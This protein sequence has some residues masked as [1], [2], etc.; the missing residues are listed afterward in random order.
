[1]KLFTFL[2]LLFFS[3][4]M[5]FSIDINTKNIRIIRDKYGVPHI[6]GKTDEEVAYGLGWA[7]AED[8]FKSM[9]ENFLTSRG[10]LAE[11]KGKDG[12]IMDFLCTVLGAKQTVDKLYD[13][14]FSPKFKDMLSAYV[15][16]VNKFADKHP[17]QV[18]LKDAFPVTEKDIIIGYTMGLA[19]M[20][21]V[22]FDI[23]KITNGT[24][25]HYEP[26]TMPKGSNGF[27]VNSHKTKDG[28][29]YLGINSHQPL[30]GPYSWYEAHLHSDEGWNMLGGTFPG[31]LTIFHGTNENLGW[32]H[33]VSFADYSDVYKLRMHPTEKLTYYYNG[34]WLRLIEKEC[35]MKVK[36]FWFIK[37]PVT[38]KY[39][40]SVYGPTLEHDGSFYSLRFP[41]AFDIRGAEQWYHMNKAK[42]L[43]EFK[44]CLKMQ[45][46]PGLNIV[47][48]DNK[49]NI[50]YID[51]GQF[52]KR[53]KHYN[54]WK[55]VP[56]DTSATLWKA[57]DYYPLEDM[58]QVLNPDCGY[59]FNNNNSPCNCTSKEQCPDSK[60]SVL[61]PYYFPY[62]DNRSLRAAYLFS[63]T[64]KIDY[65]GFK[66]IKYDQSFMNPAYNYAMINI[67][68]ILH[69]DPKKYPQIKESIAVAKRWNR[70]GD[71]NN[72]QAAI[73][74]LVIHDVIHKLIDEG[75][76]P[77]V[78]CRVKEKFL[79]E[80]IEKAQKHLLK[81]FG[82]IEVPLGDLQKLVR[83]NIALPVGGLPDVIAA[84]FAKEYKHGKTQSTV[85]DSY[86][87]MVQFTKNGPIIESVSPYGAS[88]NEGSKHYTD[89]MQL[90]VSHHLKKMSM[91]Y[92]E[93][94]RDRERIYHPL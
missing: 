67:E 21:N 43:E 48:A 93:I 81:Y 13:K 87:E 34:R 46:L 16:A 71:V 2:I 28:N 63:S 55:V 64:G 37:I 9:Q 20:T 70:S 83:G 27:A 76:F 91:N 42:N 3:V 74:S 7:T 82:T 94:F 22:Q 66:K 33:T 4:T 54:W 88:N 56:G 5:S 57:N 61:A 35:H 26:L 25:K 29:T 11:V 62:D 15:K 24:I 68:D 78:R 84:T 23:M 30:E 8:D 75:N 49:D 32:A 69:L 53:D 1:M 85:G 77:S 6:Y 59:V 50:F 44:A 47:Y 79:V 60:N 65:E 45:A 17:D 86:I 73:V 40:Q 39:Y 89:Q 14:S 12:A 52:P 51:N 90:Y 19:L 36:L 80:T 58:A 72:K 31:G 10:R 92:D 38:K 18:W 41:A